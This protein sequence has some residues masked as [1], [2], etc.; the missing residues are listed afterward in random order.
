ME[1][2]GYIRVSGAAQA[3]KDGPKRQ[4]AAIEAFCKQNG[5]QLRKIY[6]DLG[7]SGTIEGLHRPSL[8]ELITESDLAGVKIIVVENMNRL[9]RDLIVSEM[10]I[11]ELKKRSIKLYATDLGFYDQVEA[12]CDPSRKLIRQIFGAMA[13]Y[14]KSALVLKLRASR[15]RIRR[16]T[17]RCEGS[18]GYVDDR[19]GRKAL[20]VIITLRESGSNWP[21]VAA[22]LNRDGMKTLNGKTWT[23]DTTRHAFLAAK[24]RQK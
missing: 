10:I 1:A 6:S 7:V 4:E 3:E 11:R 9:A 16:D 8:M 2:Y 22:L 12:D 18:I 15:E 21:S 24:R 20:N 17:G 14:E 19:E 5:I 23:A 13:E